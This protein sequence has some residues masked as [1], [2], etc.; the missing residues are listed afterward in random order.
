MWDNPPG[1][2]H[3][4]IVGVEE[5][6]PHLYA[7]KKALYQLYLVVPGMANRRH[8]LYLYVPKLLPPG[9]WFCLVAKQAQLV[10]LIENVF[11]C[12]I[13]NNQAHVPT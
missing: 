5:P 9:K 4:G 13:R 1:V 11:V 6:S 2:C 3:N 7:S 8:I 12:S 10:L